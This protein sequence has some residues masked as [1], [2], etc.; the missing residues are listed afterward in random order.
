MISSWSF[1]IKCWNLFGGFVKT[2]FLM[3]VGTFFNSL[4]NL[5]FSYRVRTLSENFSGLSRKDFTGFSKT[6]FNVSQESF[7][8]KYFPEK[9]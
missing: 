3:S 9:N 4:K 1:L 2:A 5:C 6:A 8:E 7:V